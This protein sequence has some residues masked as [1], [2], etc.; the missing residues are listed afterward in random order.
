MTR[1]QANWVIIILLSILVTVSFGIFRNRASS[2]ADKLTTIQKIQAPLPQDELATLMGFADGMNEAGIARTEEDCRKLFEVI[3]NGKEVS[4]MI[5]EKRA[6][7]VPVGTSVKIIKK[8]Q[9]ISQVLVLDGTERVQREC[10]HSVIFPP[11]FS[12]LSAF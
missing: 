1:T 7:A 9:P 8:G 6:A 2:R 10:F 3:S 11:F 5:D 12:V 4:R